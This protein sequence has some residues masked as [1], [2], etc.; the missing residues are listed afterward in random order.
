MDEKDALRASDWYSALHSCSGDLVVTDWSLGW[1]FRTCAQDFYGGH[2]CVPKQPSGKRI[3]F[4]QTPRFRQGSIHG[5]C[6]VC[7]Q[8]KKRANKEYYG[9]IAT[10]LVD[11]NKGSVISS[12]RSSTSHYT[13]QDCCVSL[14]IGCKPPTER[15]QSIDRYVR[16]AVFSILISF[17]FN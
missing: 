15:E 6:N 10:I 17:R 4:V 5:I 3:Y 8:R 7:E 13:L 9:V 1:A 2:S 12:F 16:S 14:E 11:E